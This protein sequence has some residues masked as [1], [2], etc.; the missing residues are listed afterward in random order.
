MITQVGIRETPSM[1]SLLTMSEELCKCTAVPEVRPRINQLSPLDIHLEETNLSVCALERVSETFQRLALGHGVR[2]S[3]IDHEIREDQSEGCSAASVLQQNHRMVPMRASGCHIPSSEA[4]LI[5]LTGDPCGAF[6]EDPAS[7]PSNILAS[8]SSGNDPA[9]PCSPRNTQGGANLQRRRASL[10]PRRSNTP[11][12]S[13]ASAE[14][15][16]KPNL[17]LET[18]GIESHPLRRA[19][20]R[21]RSAPIQLNRSAKLDKRGAAHLSFQLVQPDTGEQGGPLA[22]GLGP[23]GRP[24]PS[25]NSAGLVQDTSLFEGLVA[26]CDDAFGESGERSKTSGL[27]CPVQRQELLAALG[28]EITHPLGNALEKLAD[29][30]SS[31]HSDGNISPLSIRSHHGHKETVD[32]IMDQI[33]PS[34]LGLGGDLVLDKPPRRPWIRDGSD[35]DT[36]H[37][38]FKHRRLRELEEEI[39]RLYLEWIVVGSRP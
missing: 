1:G 33:R 14:R 38:S 16:A 3:L 25:G 12:V 30:G 36:R 2:E 7:A 15:R 24:T 28:D 10:A 29:P 21:A 19:A 34:R 11:R 8:A 27:D 31:S 39:S 26:A 6:V 35:L 4:Q 13:K 9:I 32:Q 18:L 37:L 22:A 5:S 17:R 23:H 20:A